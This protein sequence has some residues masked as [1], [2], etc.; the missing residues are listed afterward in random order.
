MTN[1]AIIGET[2]KDYLV[3]E[4]D[5]VKTL[6]VEQEYINTAKRLIDQLAESTHWKCNEFDSQKMLAM[7]LKKNTN[8]ITKKE[9]SII[10]YTPKGY[11]FAGVI[12]GK[13]VF[14]KSL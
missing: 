9:N 12:N 5:Y 2:I 10:L 8:I 1:L 11:E 13:V 6:E 14:T 7:F 3:T 4:E